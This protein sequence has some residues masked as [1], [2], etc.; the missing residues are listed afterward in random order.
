[1]PTDGV[2]NDGE[3]LSED[4]DDDPVRKS[5]KKKKKK[6]KGKRKTDAAGPDAK[7]LIF[8]STIQSIDD[9][10]KSSTEPSKNPFDYINRKTH[11]IEILPDYK[12]VGSSQSDVFEIRNKVADQMA[13]QDL[14]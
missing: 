12:Y 14:N 2:A 5:T 8:K 11:K 1:M 4:F 3:P 9:R 6:K 7:Y 13:L 10:F